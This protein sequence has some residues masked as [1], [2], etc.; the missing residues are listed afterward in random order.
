MLCTG[1][2]HGFLPTQMG[3]FGWASGSDYLGRKN[4]YFV[5]GLGI[6][7]TLAVPTLTAMIAASSSALPLALYYAGTA[8]I[9][10]FYG[11]LF[12]VL[13]AYIADIFGLKHAGMIVH[14]RQG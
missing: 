4:T 7:V 6:P 10:S 2:F 5:F 13:P 3:R 9:V 1:I 12:A 8:L 14:F 11:G